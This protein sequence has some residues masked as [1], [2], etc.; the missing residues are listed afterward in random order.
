MS[1]NKF[2][3]IVAIVSGFL[4]FIALIGAIISVHDDVRKYYAM[5]AVPL[6]LFLIYSEIHQMRFPLDLRLYIVWMFIFSFMCIAYGS[7]ALAF[8]I[9]F[10]A[11]YLGREFRVLT[12]HKGAKL[13]TAAVIFAGCACFQLRFS[14]QELFDSFMQFL[15]AC[16]CLGLLDFVM[17]HLREK[18]GKD[19]LM[20]ANKEN[21]EQYFSEDSFT[22]RDKKMLKEVLSGCKYEEIASIHN[23]SLSSVKKRLAYLYKKVGVTNQI[24]FII[25]F[26]GK[27]TVDLEADA[28]TANPELPE[29]K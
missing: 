16:S 8:M 27:Q 20:E 24:D 21:I 10:I 17:N 1:K 13:I 3:R 29:S 25:K 14:K 4:I 26:T 2:W 19:I 11:V 28:A 23:L 9:Y 22:E 6:F 5:V 18:I 7:T 15:G 12:E